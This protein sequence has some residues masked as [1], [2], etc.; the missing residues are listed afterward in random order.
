MRLLITSPGP[1]AADLVASLSARGHD[2]VAVP[3]ITPE[4]IDS[5]EVKLEGA[6]GFLV[7][8]AESVRALA[9]TVAVRFFPL[10]A[11]NAEVAKAAKDAGF[12]KIIVAKGDAS[13]FAS[14][15]ENTVN[16]DAGALVHAC[17]SNETTAVTGMLVNMGYAV[18][19][20]KLY[21]LN[22]ADALPR[23]LLADLKADAYDGAVVLSVD[24]ARAFTTLLQRAELEHL[25]KDWVVYATS[26]LAS[27]PMRAL[28][29]G[30]T[31]V[32]PD[33]DVETLLAAFDQDLA[34]PP[35][36]E[37]LPEPDPEP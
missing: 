31:V 21:T 36:P 25:V 6:Q 22:R 13:D 11:E 12:T 23:S 27:A 8:S 9:D 33:P 15:I 34:N 10:F 14:L 1:E 18:R 24:E 17:H 16:P 26:T 29:V 37:P 35:E 20:L 19:P 3:L 32:A 30:R 4:R 7:T 28:K 2:V 5:P